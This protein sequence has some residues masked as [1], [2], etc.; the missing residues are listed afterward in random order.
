METQVLLVVMQVEAV[1]VHL[2]QVVR[3][4][5]IRVFLGLIVLCL[6]PEEE[7][8]VQ[9]VQITQVAVVVVALPVDMNIAQV[10][11]ILMA[12]HLLVVLIGAAYLARA[13]R[14]LATGETKELA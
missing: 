1:V 14:R 13:K 2:M 10:V 4:V 5:A 9:D 11:A 12:V 7:V 8:V 3:A 6:L